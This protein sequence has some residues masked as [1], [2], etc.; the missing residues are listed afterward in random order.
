MTIVGA[1]LVAAALAGCSVQALDT[2]G[3]RIDVVTDEPAVLR[4]WL[5]ELQWLDDQR[6]LMTL[7]VP[8]SGRLSDDP[9]ATAS[10]F[11]EV[12]PK[13]A[14]RRRVI[15]RGLRDGIVISLG[16]ARAEAVANKWTNVLVVTSVPGKIP[17]EDGDDIPDVVDNCPGGPDPCAP[18]DA[19]AGDA[20]GD[21]GDGDGALLDGAGDSAA[22]RGD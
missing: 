12:E 11:I 15:A 21:G 19:G 8:E 22:E 2:T 18:A 5:Y 10:I 17:D 14:G 3:V 16:A 13:Q 4:P 6:R 20:E 1:A 7:K 9:M